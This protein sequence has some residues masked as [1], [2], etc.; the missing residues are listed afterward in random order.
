MNLAT[1]DYKG[2]PL[3]LIDRSYAGYRARRYAINHTNQNVWIP[4]KHLCPDGTIKPGEDIDYVFRRS[5]VQLHLAGITC[6]IP[7]IKRRSC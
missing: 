7:G 6:A 4:D 1:Q 2:I 3:Q 5:R